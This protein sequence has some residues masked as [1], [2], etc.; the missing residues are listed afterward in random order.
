MPGFLDKIFGGGISSIVDSV[1]N[2][3]DKFITTDQEKEDF[4]LKV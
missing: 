2:A 3:A 1:T 4:K